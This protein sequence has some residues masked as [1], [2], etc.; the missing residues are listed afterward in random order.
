MMTMKMKVRVFGSWL[1]VVAASASNF[2]AAQ[3]RDQI[4]KEIRKELTAEIEA[5]EAKIKSLE[6]EIQSIK[7]KIEGRKR[8]LDAM[9]T[10]RVEQRIGGTASPGTLSSSVPADPLKA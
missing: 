4:E 9:V 8:N 10:A 1:L 5:K 6:A 2:V 7:L 3:S